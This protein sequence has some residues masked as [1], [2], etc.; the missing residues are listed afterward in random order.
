MEHT[1]DQLRASRGF[2]QVQ[3]A[4]TLGMTQAAVSKLEFRSDS[5]ISSVRKY[6]EALGGRLEIHAVF[7]NENV[8]IRGLDGDDILTQIRSLLR[9]IC[10]VTPP[11]IS[12]LPGKVDDRFVIRGIDD[13]E[14]YLQLEK[15]I[16]GHHVAVP[17]RRILEVR[18]APPHGKYPNLTLDGHITINTPTV[19]D[20]DFVERST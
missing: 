6:I 9:A 13:D 8:T 19:N 5:Y 4:Q 10:R 15:H 14:R 16:G 3:L 1:L 17:I 2:T 7:E 12:G 11:P 18:Q 20:C